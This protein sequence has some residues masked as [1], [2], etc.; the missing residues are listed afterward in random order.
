MKLKMY[1][2]P[3]WIVIAGAVLHLSWGFLVLL[4]PTAMNA[5]A[6]YLLNVTTHQYVAG[7]ALLASGVCGLLFAMS[8]WT[9]PQA[10]LLLAPLV[11]FSAFSGYSASRAIWLSQFGDGVI[12]SRAFIMADQLP[13]VIYALLL[14][15]AADEVLDRRD[16]GSL[17]RMMP[18]AVKDAE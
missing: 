5:T 6:L 8:R 10:T 7:V 4:N 3:P 17:L 16:I 18:K 11:A 15:I 1:S 13:Y 14:L 9:R 2:S 12:R